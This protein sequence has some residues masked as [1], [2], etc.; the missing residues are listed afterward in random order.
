MARLAAFF[1][2]QKVDREFGEPRDGITVVSVGEDCASRRALALPS[3]P[4]LKHGR[5]IVDQCAMERRLDERFLG[6]VDVTIID[7]ATR[8]CAEGTLADLSKGGVCV[9]SPRALSV[10]AVVRLELADSVLYGCVV[11][12][13]GDEPWFRIGIELI[14]V[15]LGATDMANLL[16]AVLLEMLP[17]TPGLVASPR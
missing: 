7:L 11:H 15:L 5:R 6:H 12:C 9:L 8:D 16:N 14:Q 3:A 4:T 10:E 13:T 2:K 17:A 1:R